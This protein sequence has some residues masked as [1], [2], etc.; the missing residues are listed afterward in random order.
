MNAVYISCKT[1]DGISE[2]KKMLARA[3]GAPS[4][5]ETSCVIT[6]ARHY[7]ALSRAW[8][9]LECAQKLGLE[10]GMDMGLPLELAAVHLKDALRELE[11]IVGEITSEDVLSA[12]FERFCIG[13]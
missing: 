10:C 8:K 3:A 1:G 13:K 11:S 4:K 9:E 7:E 12:V 5:E 6:S 2:L